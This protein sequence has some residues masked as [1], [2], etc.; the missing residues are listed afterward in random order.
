MK[1][2]I[3]IIEDETEIC[4]NLVKIMQLSGYDTLNAYDGKNGLELAMN[5][6]P[7]LIL[8]D[9]MMPGLDGFEILKKLQSNIETAAIPF[10]FISAKSSKHDIREAMNLGADDFITKP[11]D[12]DELLSAVKIRLEKKLRRESLYSNK[13]EKLQTNLRKTMPHEIRTPLNVILGFSEFLMKNNKM[14][15]EADALDIIKNIHQ[16]GQRL[17]R[18]FENYLLYANLELISA[19]EEE[20]EKYQKSKTYMVDIFIRDVVFTKANEYKREEDFELELVDATVII[21][22]EH[23]KKLTDELLDNSLKFS[24]RGTKIIVQSKINGNF[25]KL[26]IKDAGRGLSEEQLSKLGDYVQFDRSK[27]EQQGTGLGLSIV[28]KIVEI[29]KGSFNISS[30]LDEFTEFEVIL[31]GFAD[32]QI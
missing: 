6:S 32:S 27:Y 17:Q 5:E 10:L 19:S 22:E 2:K 28:R 15:Q 21:N 14:L 26:N 7:D 23:F 3:L 9:I 30:K 11:Y 20:K 16:S 24:E 1:Q 4:N 31:P 29:Y 25:F 8:S 12:I 18:T 13:I